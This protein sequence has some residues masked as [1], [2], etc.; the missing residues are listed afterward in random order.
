[1]GGKVGW[2]VLA[3]VPA[4]TGV[5]A[6][7]VEDPGVAV[8]VSWATWAVAVEGFAGRGVAVAGWKGVGVAVALG[9]AVI[10]RYEWA[11]DEP[12]AGWG[13]VANGMEQ[14]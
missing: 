14:P 11:E 1:V 12:P 8:P 13:S 6:A 4:V 7:F 5:P 10:K 3:G 2:A 9:S